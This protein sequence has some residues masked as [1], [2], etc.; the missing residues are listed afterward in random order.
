MTAFFPSQSILS[1]P[2][3]SPSF[4]FRYKKPHFLVSLIPLPMPKTRS[5]SHPLK[6]QADCF[7]HNQDPI[8]IVSSFKKASSHFFHFANP[9]KC[10]SAVQLIFKRNQ[11]QTMWKLFLQKTCKNSGPLSIERSL[12]LLGVG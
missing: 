8:L 10:T 6:T 9:K 5:M 12:S 1:N 3:S 2:A 11:N 7:S 4:I